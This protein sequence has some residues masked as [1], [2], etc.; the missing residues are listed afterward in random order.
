[1][2]SGK[3]KMYKIITIF[4]ALF[5]VSSMAL[6]N[7]II[8]KRQEAMQVVRNTM[9]IL[10][11][12]AKGGS[13]Y[14]SF[15]AE[16]SLENMLEAMRPY[17]SYFPLGSETGSKTQAASAIWETSDNFEKLVDNFV[18]DIELALSS[19]LENAELFSENFEIISKN[20]RSCHMNYRSR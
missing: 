6:G 16:T 10:G 14:D 18:S 20:C 13:E 9:K 17:K 11:P 12:M 3:I 2:R 1:M 15:L 5:A 4:L 19:D 7:E 8:I